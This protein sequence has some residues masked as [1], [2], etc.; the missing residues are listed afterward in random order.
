MRG[1][2]IH[3]GRKKIGPDSP[4]FVV[5]EIGIN[6]GGML[7][8][9]LR[10]VD[11][12]ADSG[13]DAVKFQTFRTDRLMVHTR[14]RFA[15]Q[16]PGA[17]TA[18]DLFQRMELSWE[19]HETLKRRA[20]E[21]GVIFLSTPFDEESVDFLDRLGVPAFK[22][23]SSDLTH[24]P[25]LRRIAG[26]NKPVF[27]STGMSFLNEVAD[28]IQVLI[29]AGANEMVLLHCVSTYPASPESLNL[30]AIHTLRE[31]FGLPAGYSDH[32]QGILFP[33]LAAALGAQVI[34]KHL[35]LDKNAAGPDHKV[36]MDPPEL[37]ELVRNLRLAE[38]GLG[39]G[40][41]R[42]AGTEARNREL[43][44][45]SIV[46]AARIGAGETITEHLLAFKRPGTGIPP[47]DAHR[48][49]GMRARRDLDA[50]SILGWDDLEAP[51]PICTSMSAS[52]VDA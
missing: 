31:V 7:P 26:K 13:A 46:T 10:L 45:R 50:D 42:P 14:D 22:V 18:Y 40:R 35:T 30:R 4:V 12:A 44:R 5:A 6:H 16:D 43:S 49:I 23:A 19:D 28:A 38:S 27:L 9:A 51:E 21:K 24:E 29:A 11:A 32:S 1:K 39:D 2:S 48:L 3:V 25:M 34:E 17:E 41:K 52:L 33:L 20:D 8:E 36:S 37:R 47:R 15:Q